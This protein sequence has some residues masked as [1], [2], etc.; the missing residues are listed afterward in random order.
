MSDSRDGL[1]A[2]VM[3]R[4]SLVDRF[5]SPRAGRVV[6]TNGCFDILH[7]GHVEYLHQARALGDHLVI[8]LNSDRSVSRLKGAG[9]P[10]VPEQDRA[11][12]L[13]ALESVGAVTIFP[14][15][16]PIGL[17]NAL[18]PDVLVKGGDYTRDQIVGADVVEDAGGRV[19][20][21]D[22]VPGRSTTRTLARITGEE[23]E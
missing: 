10:V 22:L 19:V 21:I 5:G 17:I 14:E 6:F 8:G 7:R 18:V 23:N 20:V 12:V 15:D 4:Q 16:T 3:S 2:K 13:A 9:R 11:I 1:A